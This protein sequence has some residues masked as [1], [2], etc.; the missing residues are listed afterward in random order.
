VIHP[1]TLSSARQRHGATHVIPLGRLADSVGVEP[2]A[3]PGTGAFNIWGNTFPAEELPAGGTVEVNGIPFLFP[4]ADGVRADHLRCRG[5]RIPLPASRADWIHV[6]GA[7]ERRTEDCVVLEYADGTS[8]RQWLRMSDFWPQTPPRF[9]DRLA[10]R[11]GAMLYPRHVQKTM[12]P[13]IWHQR[14][15]VAVADGL[16]ALVLPDN[17]ALHIF[18]MTL[19]DEEGTE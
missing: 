10:F 14:I 6:L 15:P 4:E 8:R 19:V 17:P 12:S 5:Q 2:S 7:A 18:A 3:R 16:T 13:A 9:G 11:T 1:S